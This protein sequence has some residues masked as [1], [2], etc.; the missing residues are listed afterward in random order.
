[1]ASARCSSVGHI[2]Q[3]SE[4]EAQGTSTGKTYYDV[5]NGI[6]YT[7]GMVAP[8]RFELSSANGYILGLFLL[9]VIFQASTAQL[10]LLRSLKGFTPQFIPARSGFRNSYILKCTMRISRLPARALSA[11]QT[12]SSLRLSKVE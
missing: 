3:G 9:S 8:E 5:Q 2:A 7:V 11:T 12:R 6:I 1:M 10:R 4:A